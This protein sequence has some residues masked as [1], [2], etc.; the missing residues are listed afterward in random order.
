MVKSKLMLFPNNTFFSLSTSS[1]CIFLT[2]FAPLEKNIYQEILH[3]LGI[4]NSINIHKSINI[5]FES[6]IIVNFQKYFTHFLLYLLSMCQVKLVQCIV[7]VIG[8]QRHPLHAIQKQIL[9]LGSE[10]SLCIWM[11]Y[12]MTNF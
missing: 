10:V 2:D 4:Y 12:D 3:L 5:T 9:Q 6:K 1:F 11:K 7:R 8:A